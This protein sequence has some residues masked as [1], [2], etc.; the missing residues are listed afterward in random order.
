MYLRLNAHTDIHQFAGELHDYTIRMGIKPDFEVGMLPIKDIRHHL[1]SEVPFTLNFMRLFMAAGILLLFSAMFNFLNL[2]LDLFRLRLRELRQRTVHGATRER[3]IQQ[4][5]FE[6]ACS[7]F[8]AVLLGGC[9]VLLAFPLF[10]KLLDLPI[11]MRELIH[12]FLIYGIG[13]IAFML[14]IG[15]A[16]FWRLSHL[17]MHQLSKGKGSGQPMLRRMT[18]T[19]QLAVSIIFIVAA[20][21]VM[22]QIRFVNEKD[23]GFNRTG[24][25][26]L[27]GLPPYMERS[28]RTALIHELE[29]VP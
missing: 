8:L 5:L 21:V 7:I 10:S 11:E 15:L 29:G 24:I 3:L 18:V 19:L 27:Y 20:L 28:L 25:I 23:L 9:F 13:I 12:L 2:H 26:Q 14:L 6:L 17:A 22:R 4:M 1:N 16:T